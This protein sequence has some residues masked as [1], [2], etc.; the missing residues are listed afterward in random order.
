M[1]LEVL[2]R[3]EIAWNTADGPAFGAAYRTDASFVNIRGEHFVGREAI[4]AGHDAI[5]HTVYA[6]SQD[7]ARLKHDED[8][9]AKRMVGENGASKPK[10]EA[11]S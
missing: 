6:G 7:D 8:A 10:D 1:A 3:L 4:G 11:A 9:L 5:L 2:D